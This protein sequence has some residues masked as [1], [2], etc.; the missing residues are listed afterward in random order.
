MSRSIR[1]SNRATAVSKGSWSD[2]RVFA[3]LSAR[4]APGRYWYPMR[5]RRFVSAAV[6]ASLV[7]VGVAGCTAPTP[8]VAPVVVNVEDLPGARIE[9]PLNS[10]L[11]VIMDW[12][13]VA[14]YTAVIADPA[15]AE[16]VRGAETGEAAYSPGFTPKQVGETAVTLSLKDSETQDVE[17]TLDVTP[18]PAG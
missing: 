16:F 3:A 17:F 1:S 4:L 5:S 12:S 14:N 7:V 15:I 9:V 6:A 2:F 10:T 18:A 8:A 11:V 13:E